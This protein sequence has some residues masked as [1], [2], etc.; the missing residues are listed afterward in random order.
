MMAKT[1]EDHMLSRVKKIIT[2]AAYTSQRICWLLWH[3]ICQTSCSAKVINTTEETMIFTTDHMLNRKK[4]TIHK[5]VC[6][7]L[8][9]SEK[10]VKLIFK[11]IFKKFHYETKRI[12]SNHC[13]CLCPT[14]MSIS[15]F[16]DERLGLIYMPLLSRLHRGTPRK[17]PL[18]KPN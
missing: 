3:T 1:H 18:E 15:Y 8:T 5:S 14:Q 17:C 9:S 7:Q 13:H 16:I 4:F 11:N 6:T 12:G 2:P 10:Y